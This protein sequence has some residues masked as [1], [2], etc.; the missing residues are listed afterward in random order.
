MQSSQS[1]TKNAAT[2]RKKKARVISLKMDNKTYKKVARK[3]DLV[4]NLKNNTYQ[5][6]TMSQQNNN[7]GDQRNFENRILAIGLVLTIIGLTICMLTLIYS[8]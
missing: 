6:S 8:K 2:F 3:L 5:T 7:D 4:M 1:P